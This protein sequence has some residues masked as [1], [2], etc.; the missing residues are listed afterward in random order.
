MRKLMLLMAGFA[1][2]LFLD[3]CASSNEV[4]GGGMFQ[5]R[6]YTGGVYWDRTEKVK[7]NKD[8]EEYDIHRLEEESQKKYVSTTSIYGENEMFTEEEESTA[9]ISSSD[10]I[11]TIESEKETVKEP[12]FKMNLNSNLRSGQVLSSMK[13]NVQKLSSETKLTIRKKVVPPASD[14]SLGNI[15]MIILLIILIILVFSLLDSLLGGALSWILSIL[16]LIL[17][18]YFIL[19]LLGVV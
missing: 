7:K 1:G 5:K 15:L 12:A 3:S 16:L 10:N 18:I 13:Q 9:I 17:L 8:H 14:S 4:V 11:E 19:R 6:K 2:I